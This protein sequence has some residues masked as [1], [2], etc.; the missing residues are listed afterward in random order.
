MIDIHTHFF[1]LKYLPI[2]GI[3]VRYSNGIVSPGIARGIEKLL[4]RKTKSSIQIGPAIAG[5]PADEIAIVDK[6][7]IRFPE[8]EKNSILQLTGDETINRV[9]NKVGDS[10]LSDKE[11]IAAMEEFNAKE[12][13]G[14]VFTSLF[15]IREGKATIQDYKNVFGLLRRMLSWLADKMKDGLNYLRWFGFMQNSEHKMLHCLRTVD[16]PGIK[17][18]VHQLLDIDNFFNP[19]GKNP[20]YPSYFSYDVQV[21]KMSKLN[22]EFPHMLVGMVGFDPGKPD[23]MRIIDDAIQRQGFKAIKFYPPLGYRAFDDPV[24][25]VSINKLFDYCIKN[26]VAIFTHCNNEGFEADPKNH[27]GYN[28]NP[29]HW[30]RVL[31]QDKYRNLRLCLA[32]AGG[33]QGWFAEVKANDEIYEKDIQDLP[34]CKPGETCIDG[35]QEDWNSSYAKIAYKLC[36]VY[37]NVYCDAA[38]LDELSNETQRGYFKTRL[39]KLF[40]EEPRFKKKIIYGSDWHM[41]YQEAKNENYFRGYVDLFNEPGF[42]GENRKDFFEDNAKRY[43]KL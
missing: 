22:T 35:R 14:F 33:I 37:P 7:G 43:L 40:S 19:P 31:E 27:S 26:D 3:I 18:F 13:A 6:L 32:H 16:E 23:C 20:P 11:V 9:L 38:Y 12:D 5:D 8:G 25:A 24:H 4:V 29:M 17:R 2:A 10:D 34:P 30:K 42:T 1:N 36:L 15:A 41:L 28:S 39:L 21:K